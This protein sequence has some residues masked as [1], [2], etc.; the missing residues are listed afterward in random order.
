MVIRR[1][2]GLAQQRERLVA[3]PDAVCATELASSLAIR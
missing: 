1:R 2:D 3:V